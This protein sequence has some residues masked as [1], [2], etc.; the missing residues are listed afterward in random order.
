M[1]KLRHRAVSLTQ[2]YVENDCMTRI[3]FILALCSVAS[4]VKATAALSTAEAYTISIKFYAAAASW[5]CA[6]QQAYRVITYSK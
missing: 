6:K 5:S 1:R 4:H 3:L 2:D